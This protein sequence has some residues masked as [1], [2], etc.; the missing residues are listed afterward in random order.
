MMRKELKG[1]VTVEASVVL[2]M[3]VYILLLVVYLAFYQYSNYALA[4]DGY[5]SAF[6]GSRANLLAGNSDQTVCAAMEQFMKEPLP[7]VGGVS[8]ETK[9]GMWRNEIT[10]KGS[11]RIPFAQSVIAGKYPISMNVY[12]QRTEPALFL[13]NCRKIEERRNL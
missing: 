13:R 5:V 9:S 8:Y 6:R 3:I 2:P 12:A 11:I 10:I 7:G 4:A 1:S